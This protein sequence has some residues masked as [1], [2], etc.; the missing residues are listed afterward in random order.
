MP[1]KNMIC[2]DL[3]IQPDGK[4]LVAGYAD[5]GY[6]GHHTM[7]VVRLKGNGNLD[8][9]FASSGKFTFSLSIKVRNAGSWL[10]NRMAK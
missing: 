5:D 10:C 9:S 6:G 7:I 8:N 2:F 3:L 4:I 1:N